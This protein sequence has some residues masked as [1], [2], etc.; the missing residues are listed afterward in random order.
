M[1]D[2]NK[3]YSQ[4]TMEQQDIKDIIKLLNSAIQEKDME[5]VEDTIEQLKEYLDDYTGID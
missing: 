3:L 4:H 5:I 2:R 1:K